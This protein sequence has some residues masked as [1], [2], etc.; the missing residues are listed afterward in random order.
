[1]ANSVKIQSAKKYLFR[2]FII[3]I[4]EILINIKPMDDFISK[5]F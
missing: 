2:L 4:S 5:F 1:M 3:E